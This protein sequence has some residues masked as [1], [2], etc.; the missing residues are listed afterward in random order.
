MKRKKKA[1]GEWKKKTKNKKN[2]I[3]MWGMEKKKHVR[4][5]KIFSPHVLKELLTRLLC[6]KLFL[7][8]YIYFILSRLRKC[9]L[10]Y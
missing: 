6:L 10:N 8:I 1:C 2:R 7:Y 5:T 9:P 4:K 3:N